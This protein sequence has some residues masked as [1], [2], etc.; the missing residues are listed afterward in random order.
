MPLAGDE[1]VNYLLLNA[2]G[3][4]TY[5][6]VHHAAVDAHHRMVGLQDFHLLRAIGMHGA[7]VE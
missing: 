4:R 3:E 1:E 2:D 6:G 7:V 5:R